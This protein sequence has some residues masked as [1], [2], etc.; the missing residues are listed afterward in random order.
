MQEI[1]DNISILAFI[2]KHGIKTERNEPLDLKQH[3]FL[4]DIFSDLSPLQVVM[5][6]AQVG[7]TTLEIIKLFWVA[8]TKKMEIIFTMPTD[9][10]IVDFVGSRVNRI[11][12]NNP[13]FQEW[14][15][16]RD[17]IET[18]KIGDAMCYF[19]GTHTK[20]AAISVPADCVIHD[21][22][23]SS[24]QMV[25]ADYESR[26][27]HSKYKWRWY[28]SHPSTEGTGVHKM[29]VRSDQKHWLIRCRSCTQE[30]YLSWPESI[31]QD[32]EIYVCKHCNAGLSD[33]ERR[34]GRWAK[35]KGM[36]DQP[37][38]GYWISSLMCP[39]V[40][41][42]EIVENFHNKDPE[43]F[44]TKVLGLPYVGGG[45]KVLREDITKNLTTKINDQS[46]RIVIGCDTGKHV[47]YVVGNSQGLF[48][49][50][51]DDGY[52]GIEAL[53]QRWPKS[54]AVFDQG[55][56]LIAPRKLRERYKG[57]VYLYHYEQDRKT[58]QLIRWGKDEEEGNVKVDR[59]RMIEVLIGEFRDGRV[60]IQGN[61]TDWHEFITHFQNVYRVQEEDA[62][63]VI[64]RRWERGGPDHYLHAALY[65][66]VGME[67]F[68]GKDPVSV[69]SGNPMFGEK[70]F[71]VS[72][73][74]R[75]PSPDTK[76]LFQ[77]EADKD[78]D[79]RR[80]A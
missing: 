68:G 16:D 9:G 40:S 33:D 32:K 29:W 77:F 48:Y 58:M 35:K 64:K 28:F 23:D 73:D 46:G 69:M 22:V 74:G 42:K 20:R 79:W 76:R 54:I 25:I 1:S 26:L 7:L 30:Q 50:G 14:T 44:S 49:Y 72:P 78:D 37:F 71:S 52:E 27:K 6:P 41:A 51:E 36:E 62:L 55:G 38:S 5:K 18:K 21:E 3:L 66:R 60:P 34:I 11:I 43:Y 39:W 19:R 53:L 65:Q 56:D 57:R 10:D 24:S 80:S 8:Y 75:M 63:G 15:A 13:I 17:N 12:A 61:E 47:H 31:D 2:F 67:R 59:N 45:N 4:F 70:S